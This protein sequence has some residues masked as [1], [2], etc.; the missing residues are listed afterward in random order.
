[1]RRIRRTVRSLVF[2][3]LGASAGA[4]WSYLFDPDRGIVR[5]RVL[6]DRA[7]AA[8]RK[9]QRHVQ[10]ELLRRYHHLRGRMTGARW[11]VVAPLTRRMRSRTPA[12]LVQKVRSEVLGLRRFAGLNVVVDGWD[13]IVVLRGV[14]PSAEIER[15]L[16]AAARSVDGVREVRSLLHPAGEPAPNKRE[17][18]GA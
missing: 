10:R 16:V 15:L 4:T 12:D 5:R 1:M 3:L 2:L 14:V 13:G 9:R 8:L 6:A 17:S 18:I 7:K 11:R